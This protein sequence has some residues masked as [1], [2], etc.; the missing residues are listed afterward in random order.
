VAGEASASLQIPIGL[1]EKHVVVLAGAGS[2]KTVLLKRIIEEA[3]LRGIPSLLVDG[4]NDLAALGDRWPSPPEAWSESDARLADIYDNTVDKIVWTPGQ[5]SGNPL[6][7]ELLPDLTATVD[8]PDEFDAAVAMVSGAL[9]DLLKLGNSK[10][11]VN[12][13]GILSKSI[14]FYIE[15]QGKGLLKYIEL[16]AD[17]PSEAMLGISKE[18]A[19]AKDISDSLRVLEETDPMISESGGVFDPA[20]LFGDDRQDS[21]RGAGTRVSVISLNSLSTPEIQQRFVNQ[22][23]T[24][25]FAWIKRNPNP[26]GRALRGLLVIDEAKDFVPARKST[27]C[28]ESLMRL[29]AQARKYHLGVVFATQNPREI[30]NT[31]IGNCSTQYYGKASSPA[32]INTIREQ[33]AT[34]GGSGDDIGRLEKGIFYVFNADANMRVP[35]KVRVPLCLSHHITLDGDEV[36]ERARQSRAILSNLADQPLAA[37]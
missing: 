20:V 2:G 27:P 37:R 35:T 19:L 4:A 32:A 13:R 18:A 33:L 15:Q 30:E 14:R 6:R 5:R 22:L 36:L 25:L 1:L 16:L 12:K 7:L 28:K 17:L 11:D 3:S 23:A 9:A 29:T 21:N 31:V 24:T 34:R 26:P 10:G 8:D